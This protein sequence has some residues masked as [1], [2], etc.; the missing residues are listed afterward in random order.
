VFDLPEG[1]WHSEETLPEIRDGE[2]HNQN[3]PDMKIG[4]NNW[5]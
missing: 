1:K 2:V 3:I 5:A 4:V